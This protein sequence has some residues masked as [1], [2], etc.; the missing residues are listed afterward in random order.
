ML[1]CVCDFLTKKIEIIPETRKKAHTWLVIDRKF[2]SKSRLV[3]D[4]I[5]IAGA[6][7]YAGYTSIRMQTTHVPYVS[8]RKF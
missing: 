3:I 4:A 2:L 8:G 1:I 6:T 7:W 5:L